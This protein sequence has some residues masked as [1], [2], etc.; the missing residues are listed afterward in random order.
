MILERIIFSVLSFLLFIIIFSKMIKRN[1]TNYLIIIILQALGI[2]IR[3]IEMIFNIEILLIIHVLTYIMSIIVPTIIIVLEKKKILFPELICIMK[4][5]LYSNS[6]KSKKILIDFIEKY[7]NSSKI[8]K[9]LAKIYENEEKYELM[10]NEYHRVI[11]I[12][13]EDYSSYYYMAL[14]LKKIDKQSEAINTLNVLLIKKPEFFE[15][16]DLLGTIYYEQERYKEAVNVYLESM[17]YN[18]MKYEI[19][20]NLGLNYSMLNDFKLANEYYSKAA[21]IN[22]ILYKAKYSLGQIALI[23]GDLDE[24]EIYFMQSLK[25]E[26]VEIGSY[27]YLA[28]IAMLKGEED[29]AINYIN[30]AI[31]LNPK[32]YDKIQLDPI[33]IKIRNRINKNRE[34]E[35]V[36]ENRN[37]LNKKELKAI[38]HLA[39]TYE[40]VGKLNNDDIKMMKNMKQKEIDNSKQR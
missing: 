19:Y 27:Y 34:Q 22:S 14:A 35:V 3:F 13:S 9:K 2:L 38:K 25:G 6:N 20:Y 33:F 24:A 18:P 5:Y 39:K 7:P 12:N 11:E 4:Y 30:I 40:L 36:T 8:H 17:K 26:E 21:E 28:Q 1:D 23:S 31:E 10:A 32:L 16:S 29:K 15:A 37:K